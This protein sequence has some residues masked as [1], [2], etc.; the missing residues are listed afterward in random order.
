[1]ATLAEAL[2]LV[3]VIEALPVRDPKSS[4]DRFCSDSSNQV[5]SSSGAGKKAISAM[6]QTHSQVMEMML[7][8]FLDPAHLWSVNE[9]WRSNRTRANFVEMV[10]YGWENLAKKEKYV[11]RSKAWM[12]WYV[13]N[14][15]MY[16]FCKS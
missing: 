16:N 3:M 8:R 4:D 6:A 12:D 13:G 10:K 1:V 5:P 15:V 2:S 14:T 11:G 9:K 7:E